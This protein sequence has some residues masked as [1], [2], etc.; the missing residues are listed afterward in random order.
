MKH[1]RQG[2]PVG[3]LFVA[4]TLAVVLLVGVALIVSSFFGK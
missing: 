2:D 3:G 4:A 1:N